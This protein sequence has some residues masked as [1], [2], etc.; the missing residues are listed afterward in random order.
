MFL[1][2]GYR[3]S[4][5]GYLEVLCNNVKAIKAYEKSGF[6]IIDKADSFIVAT[7]IQFDKT[8]QL[9][10]PDKWQ[11]EDYEHM[12]GHKLSFEHRSSVINRDQDSFSYYELNQD[13]NLLAFATVK[14]PITRW[15][16]SVSWIVI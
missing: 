13:E 4:A 9:Q 12:I 15:C 1:Q 7:D 8:L 5:Y 16:N 2:Y 11:A 10:S 6:S 3:C 14:T